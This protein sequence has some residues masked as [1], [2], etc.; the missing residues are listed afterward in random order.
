MKKVLSLF[1]VFTVAMVFSFAQV[2]AKES[3]C[4]KKCATT[5][6]QCEKDAKADKAKKEAC[7]TAKK[8]CAS[9]CEKEKGAK[10]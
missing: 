5:F 10:K 7:K 1:V 2:N 4:M 8:D 9:A 3:P 6:K